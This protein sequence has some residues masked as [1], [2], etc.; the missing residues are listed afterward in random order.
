MAC[1]LAGTALVSAAELSLSTIDATAACTQGAN[2]TAT[3]GATHPVDTTLPTN[4]ATGTDRHYFGRLHA[5]LQGPI[6]GAG[7][8]ISAPL[9]RKVTVTNSGAVVGSGAAPT[10]GGDGLVRIMARV[11]S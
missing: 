1:L 2:F 4:L 6:A 5:D 3:C 8:A 10:A 11:R 7:F 9:L